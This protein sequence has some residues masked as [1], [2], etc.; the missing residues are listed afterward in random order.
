MTIETGSPVLASDI[1]ALM[2]LSG[3]TMNGPIAMGSHALSGSAVSF[4]GGTIDGTVIGGTTAGAV[5]ATVLALGKSFALSGVTVA[6]QQPLA[7]S[8]TY[9]GAVTD[10][11]SRLLNSVLIAADTVTGAPSVHGFDINH[12][13]GGGS[14]GYGNRIGIAAL[15]HHIGQMSG[16]AGFFTGGEF[17]AWSRA[18]AGGTGLTRNTAQGILTGSNP[19]M[20]LQSGATFFSAGTGAEIDFAGE[21]GSSSKLVTG[22]LIVP[23]S[24][25]AVAGVD[26]LDSAIIIG[27][28]QGATATLPYGLVFGFQQSQWPFDPSNPYASL[29]T[30][31]NGF[32]P[33]ANPPVIAWGI[34]YLQLQAT[35][36]VFRAPGTSIDP[37]G[38]Y[39]IG[40]GYIEPQ[41][42]GLAI[43]VIGQIVTGAAVA[44][45]GSNYAGGVILKDTIGGLYQVA[46]LSGTGV[47]SVTILQKAVAKSPTA[48]VSTTCV[49]PNGSGDYGAGCTLTLTWSATRTALSL[50]PSGGPVNFGGIAAR[51]G[52]ASS[53]PTTGGVVA[54]GAG[55]SDY[56]ILGGGTLAALSVELPAAP[57]NG[58]PVRVTSQVAITALTVKDSAGS[59]ADI[60]TGPS[61]L[62]A[63]GGFSA[64]WNQAASA[65]WCDQ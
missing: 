21:T 20:R 47:A 28:Q 3:A 35:A 31:Q 40:T 7:I 52:M 36:G 64:I 18:N 1:L 17:N 9:A 45:A 16:G 54:I 58:Q 14:G 13:F 62:T 60:Q 15:A 5:T 22:L 53:T 48:T 26:G 50:N 55:I 57:A 43:D 56:R 34:D 29:I 33:S 61:S 49:T 23:L 25:H 51:L 27:A 37:A 12:Q 8:A 41:A 10:A 46:S 2:P 42:S 11:S 38:N 24:T 32:N 6:S 65:W 19:V 63:G 44:T 39:Q 4:T 30:V 59:T